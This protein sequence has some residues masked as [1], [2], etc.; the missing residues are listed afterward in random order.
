MLLLLLYF[1]IVKIGQMGIKLCCLLT[2]N[3]L[4]CIGRDCIAVCVCIA[5]PSIID[6]T[7]GKFCMFS[8]CNLEP[9]KNSENVV[10]Q[11]EL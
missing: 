7:F 3:V 6:R 2:Q 10:Y 1:R 11:Y 4:M 8:S 5:I 9:G